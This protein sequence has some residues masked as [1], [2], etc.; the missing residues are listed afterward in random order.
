[1]TRLTPQTGSTAGG[2][3]VVIKG[4][5]L[6]GAKKVF[7]GGTKATGVR[8]KSGRK[9]VV[10]A[11]PHVSGPVRVRVVTKGGGSKQ[12]KATHF[13]YVTPAP[14]LGQLT[15]RSGPTTGGAVVTISGADLAGATAVRFGSSN[16][17]SFSVTSPG[18]IRAVT[19]PRPV[20][21]V[22]VTVVTP[23]GAATLA[24]AYSF[25]AAPTLSAVTPSSGPAAGATVTLSGT[26]LTS[27]AVVTFGG[28]VATDVQSSAGGTTL[29][30]TTPP[31]APG[32]VDVVVTTPGGSASLTRGYLFVG[33]VSLTGVSPSVGPTAGFVDV[34]LTGTGFTSDTLVMFGAKPSLDVSVNP[35]GTQLTAVLPPQGAGVVDVVVTTEGDSD[36]LAGAFTYVV[37]PT[38]AGVSPT[39]GPVAGGTTVTLTGSGFRAG[40]LVGFGGVPA[41]G[42]VVTSATQ[43]TVTAPAHGPGPVAVTVSTPGGTATLPDGYTYVAIPALTS[44]SPDAGP[45]TGGTSV[46]LTGSGFRAGMQVSFGGVPATGVV[47]TSSTQAT[48]VTP[49]HAAGTVDVSV[50]T[51][52]GP[53]TLPNAYT[54]VAAP[55]LT[56]VSPDAGPTGGGTT[57]TLTGTGFRTGTQVSFGG[58]PAT[59]V[60]VTSATSAIATTPARPAGPVDVTV[61]TPGGSSGVPA[62][63]TY[64]VSPILASVTPATGPT[65]GGTSVTLTGS[66]FRAG[67]QVRFG[68]DPATVDLVNQ[69]GTQATVLAPAHTAGPVPVSVT[70]AGGYDSLSG[71]F[72]Y[73]VAPALTSLAPDAGPVAGGTTVT[74]T[75]SGFR[76]DTQV[77]FG[78]TP[79][80][81]VVVNPG[82]TELTATAPPHPAGAVDVTVSTPGGSASLSGAYTYVALP[83]LTAV[84]P[85]A[86]PVTGGTPVTLTG[87][88]FRAGMQVLFGAAAAT[89]VSVS[90]DGTQLTALP[91]AHVPGTVDVSVTT[92]GGSASFGN[93]Y[94]YL[95]APAVTGVSPA[96]GPAAGGTTITLTGTG[97]RPG[98]EVSVGG[99]PATDVAVNPAGTSLTAT[100]PP[101]PAGLVAVS[102]T[103]P[104]GTDSLAGSFTYV[105]APT[106]TSVSPVTGPT[107]GG[108]AVTIT[109]T[110]LNGATEV[111]FGGVPATTVVVVDATTLTAVTLA[112]PAGPVD[113]SVTTVGGS[114]TATD[115]FTYVA[116]PTLD[117]VTPGDGP[118]AGGTT[119]TLTGSGL[120]GTT[121]VTFDGVPATGLVVVSDAEVTVDT[122]AHAPGVVDVGLTAPGGT[123]SLV[124]GYTY[125]V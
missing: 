38:L 55:V 97:F 41:T 32:W 28:L 52:G 44:V 95:A 2:F 24:D 111:T 106:I 21:A 63:F 98:T 17:A 73:V 30:V 42:V 39:A 25:V 57:V 87:S 85:D 75:G 14:T 59:G 60:V 1:V 117:A 72:T 122:P 4:R 104:G 94:T 69:S 118:A 74:L 34:T 20:G 84:A 70:T 90:P 101:H 77:L 125:T 107:S 54:Y 64:V 92:P 65:A 18:T 79:A 115:A 96:L 89:G 37:A 61:T 5:N 26:G 78:T 67:M 33:G 82:G 62:A 15:A 31:H 29:T 51:P 35:G 88:G 22:D 58:T 81:G 19:P 45:V 105:A 71:A 23:G 11:P 109:G 110:D 102:V 93:S 9:L 12:G 76:A 36:V 43:A 113:V 123:V 46:T 53:V 40:M 49:A 27:D 91:P 66:G 6:S 120:T 50:S 119:V 7:F 68:G 8:V 86:G 83:T 114:G 13:T 100:T 103:T 3:Q 56:A 80:T 121:S 48:V 116:P 124:D 16:A 108:T 47:V 10:V 99:T 112:H